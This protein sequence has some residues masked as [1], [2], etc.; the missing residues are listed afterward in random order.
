MN[1]EAIF[2]LAALVVFLAAEAQESLD[3]AIRTCYFI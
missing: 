3:N 2:W 1:W